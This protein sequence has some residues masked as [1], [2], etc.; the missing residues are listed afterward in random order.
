LRFQEKG[1]HIGS[2]KEAVIKAAK[3]DGFF[4]AAFLIKPGEVFFIEGMG[5]KENGGSGVKC[6]IKNQGG[7]CG[8]T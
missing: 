1:K 5:L 7:M 2:E 4:G 3:G 6:R 8:L